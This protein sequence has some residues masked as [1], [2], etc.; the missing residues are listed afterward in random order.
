METEECSPHNRSLTNPEL[1]DRSEPAGMPVGAGEIHSNP[2]GSAGRTPQDARAAHSSSLGSYKCLEVPKIALEELDHTLRAAVHHC[3]NTQDPRGAW[4]VL[5]EPRIFETALAAYALSTATTAGDDLHARTAVAKASDWVA[6][7]IP[8]DHDPVARAI[9]TSLKSILLNTADEID[10][11]DSTF[12]SEVFASRARLLYAL[13][14]HAGKNVPPSYGVEKLSSDVAH[15][16][17]QSTRSEQKS[18]SRVE[19]ISIRIVLESR[20]HNYPAVA[21]ASRLLE[22]LQAPDGSFCSNPVSTAVAFLALSVSQPS[23]SAWE[24]CRAYLLS[25]Q[26]PDGT[27]RFCTSDVWD[28]TLTVRAFQL[29][30]AFKDSLRRAKGFICAHQNVDGGWPFRSGVESDTDTTAGSSASPSRIACLHRIGSRG[31]T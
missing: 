26:Q 31:I 6:N 30:P 18:W 11:D 16:L 10:L 14:V 21:Q 8:Q 12:D 22:T 17:E 27:W 25:E 3:I 9:E 15:M 4:E 13:A 2:G 23:S 29:H 24:R 5:P 7:A 1:G 28:T 20:R 19:L